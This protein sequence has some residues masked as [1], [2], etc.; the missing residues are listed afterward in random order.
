LKNLSASESTEEATSE[1][2]SNDDSFNDLVLTIPK[3]FS[4]VK[5]AAL[6]R[7]KANVS[8]LQTIK[9]FEVLKTE[10]NYDTFV[11]LRRHVLWSVNETSISCKSEF[12]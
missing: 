11:L 10:L 9:V 6:V 2:K 8:L 3:S 7:H 12:R 5:L 1:D 4:S